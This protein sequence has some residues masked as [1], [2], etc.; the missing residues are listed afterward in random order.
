MLHADRTSQKSALQHERTL[1]TRWRDHFV[2]YRFI[3]P[4][5]VIAFSNR[6]PEEVLVA[7]AVKFRAERHLTRGENIPFQ[8]DIAGSSFRPVNHK[9]RRV[10]RSLVKLSLYDPCRRRFVKVT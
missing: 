7:G 1:P 5:E 8:Q 9:T 10:A 2:S 6:S 3:T 4:D